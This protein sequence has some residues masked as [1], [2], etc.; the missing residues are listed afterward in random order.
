MAI[1]RISEWNGHRV[2][3]W[4]GPAGGRT[5]PID[6]EAEAT[7]TVGQQGNP[8][9]SDLKCTHKARSSSSRPCTSSSRPQGSHTWT[10]HQELIRASA[11]SASSPLSLA[12]STSRLGG[13]YQH[14][15][16]TISQGAVLGIFDLIHMSWQ[17]Q[18]KPSPSLIVGQGQV[19]RPILPSDHGGPRSRL[20]ALHIPIRMPPEPRFPT[21]DR[22]V[23]QCVDEHLPQ[24]PRV[25]PASGKL[26]VGNAC[27]MGLGSMSMRLGKHLAL[28]WQ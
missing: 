12:S 23:D 1:D 21:A 5:D 16:L 27:G 11:S 15:I 2:P 18:D 13:Q 20:I 17:Q 10:L 9:S 4:T 3:G 25:E 6:S 26:S 24:H 8:S 22:D 14:S 19:P 28:V 7:S